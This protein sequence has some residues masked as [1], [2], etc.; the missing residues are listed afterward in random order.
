MMNALRSGPVPGFKIILWLEN[1]A[2]EVFSKCFMRVYLCDGVYMYAASC[3]WVDYSVC[4]VYDMCDVCD[5]C[6]MCM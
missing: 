5:M 2:C 4:G 3:T 6:D 1:I